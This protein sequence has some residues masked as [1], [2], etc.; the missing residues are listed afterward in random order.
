MCVCLAVNLF[1][2][3]IKIKVG[4]VPHRLNVTLSHCLKPHSAT[5]KVRSFCS[6]TLSYVFELG[7]RM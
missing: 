6:D 5:K 7:K 2:K 3:K 4:V 1:L